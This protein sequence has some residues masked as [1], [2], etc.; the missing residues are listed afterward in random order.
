MICPNALPFLRQKII[1]TIRAVIGISWLGM[2]KYQLK[3]TFQSVYHLQDI[4]KAWWCI[5]IWFGVG[6]YCV[7]SRN[8]YS[9]KCKAYHLQMN[10]T[11][12][13][14]FILRNIEQLFN[15]LWSDFGEHSDLGRGLG[16]ITKS[17]HKVWRRKSGKSCS[18]RKFNFTVTSDKEPISQVTFSL[19][20]RISSLAIK[21]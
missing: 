9:L 20:N 8:S 6:D 7:A 18:L 16:L 3:S 4:I 5:I 14:Y 15:I 17:R 12:L 19:E 11:N 10:N 2:S 13:G 21:S 1:K